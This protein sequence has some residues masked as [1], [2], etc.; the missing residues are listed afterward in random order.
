MFEPAFGGKHP[1]ALARRRQPQEIGLVAE[2]P[3]AVLHL[4]DD[5]EIARPGKLCECRVDW[6]RG[7]WQGED[8]GKDAGK[9]HFRGW[10]RAIVLLAPGLR[11]KCEGGI[12]NAER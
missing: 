3:K 12:R 10:K 5:V 8:K 11:R 1:I 2:Q 4:P 9:A 7:K 6:R